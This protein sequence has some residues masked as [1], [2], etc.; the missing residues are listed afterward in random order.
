MTEHTTR[1]PISDEPAFSALRRTDLP[2]FLV[3]VSDN[4]ILMATPACEPLGVRTDS[5]APLPV[6]A[7]TRTMGG[8][9]GQP[10]RL[11][12]IRLPNAFV[13]RLFSCATLP[14][15]T[16]PVVL[17][18]DPDALA[19]PEDEA[20]Q[21]AP[22]PS[23]VAQ[24][25]AA[26]PAE[27]AR[28]PVRF[29][30][31]MDADGHFTALSPSFARAVGDAA[32]WIG[33]SLDDLVVD[34]A[35]EG[36]DA[37]L[38]AIRQGATFANAGIRTSGG[39]RIEIGGVPLFNGVKQQIGWRGFGLVWP[40]TP[41]LGETPVSP[42][43]S[44]AANVVPLRGSNLTPR[45]RSAFDEIARTLTTAIDGWARPPGPSHEEADYPVPPAEAFAPVPEEP[46]ESPG[47]PPA[48]ATAWDDSLLNRLPIGLAVQQDGG[49]VF[50]NDTLLAWLALEDLAAFTRAGGFGS[51]LTRDTPEEPLCLRTLSGPS[52]VDVR[53][54]KCDWHG[55]P[56]VIHVLRLAES[57]V[58]PRSRHMTVQA[59]GTSSTLDLFAFPIL[60]VDRSGSIQQANGAA[61][62]L[63]GFPADELRGEPFTLAFATESQAEAVSLLD[64]AI[65]TDSA[66]ESRHLSARSRDGV[67]QQVEVT[68]A[69]MPGEGHLYSLALRL[70]GDGGPLHGTPVPELLFPDPASP[71]DQA[72]SHFVRRVS[73]GV[74]SPLNGILGFVES[75]RASAFGP[76][77]NSRY[78]RHA[79]AAAA[80]AQQLLATL[81][82]IE[83]LAHP[84]AA[85][86]V[87][88]CT[89]FTVVASA[90]EH[91]LPAIRRRRQVLRND[92]ATE[93]T[94]RMNR[95]VLAF[96]VRS[97][98]EEAIRATPTAGQIMVSA[99]IMESGGEKRVGVLIRDGGPSLTEPQIAQALSPFQAAKASDR[100]SS[101]GRPFRLA[102]LAAVLKANGGELRLRRGV[103]SGMLCELCLPL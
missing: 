43:A 82:D 100:F 1:L 31:E 84:A 65:A 68:L 59:E 72:L 25:P 28:Q 12:R 79:E 24:P 22:A 80:A 51:L 16:G 38:D 83:A 70:V 49:I 3:A 34:A 46:A 102:R 101:S 69:R 47:V 89:L 50:L 29:T 32:R 11:E 9:V 85:E 92:C 94:V 35:L 99:Q 78:S 66:P 81:E 21:A 2:S 64:A 10:P 13:P 23:P 60:V 95:E 8:A 88:V 91:A 15:S 27:P 56:A 63:C 57:A 26:E 42:D 14:S 54:I 103:D 36:A 39:S 90:V 18:A 17:F 62:E 75:V 30:W 48:P 58:A 33:R 98:L 45:E 53:L 86:A 97:V 5:P 20:P 61:A 96:L 73:H 93:L 52:P 41:E 7:I 40:G 74:R 77:G 44:F 37:A 71:S 67:H 87:E 4:R 55:K 6:K 76:V 19:A